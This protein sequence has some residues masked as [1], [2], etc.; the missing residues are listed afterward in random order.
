MGA[1][2]DRRTLLGGTLWAVLLRG[3]KLLA[4]DTA[5]EADSVC[6]RCRGLGLVPRASAKAYVFVEGQA[7]FDPAAAAVGQ[8]CPLCMKGGDE[9]E[10]VEQAKRQHADVLAQ[11]AQWESR[12]GEKLLLVQTRHAAIHTQLKV[13]DAKRVGEAVEQMAL[14]L[15]RVASSLAITP[16]RPA[17]YSQAIL[18]GEPA[19]TKFRAAMEQ[20]FTPE[21]LGEN[22]QNAGKGI[23]YDHPAVAHC[24]LTQKVIRDAPAEYFAVKLAATRQIWVATDTRSPAWMIEG[25]AAYAQHAVL[26]SARVFTIYAQGRGPTR[27]VTLAETA[28]QAAAGQFRPWEKLL[29][30]DLRDFEVTD[31]VQSL[32][33]VAFLVED[34]PAKF[35]AFVERLK[36]GTLVPAAFEEAY[37]ATAGDLE[38]ACGKWLA[39]R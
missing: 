3:G 38:T 39:R 13:A 27:P 21:Q 5:Q 30:R 29:A 8:N 22:W 10:L 31:Y 16:T 14:R 11:H 7:E 24:Y 25:M 36:A 1:G 26:G 9:A 28:R 33:M 2:L 17:G 12:L 19:W 35:L 15:Q 34:Q 18:W 4:Q 20:H 32:A 6:R 37:G 23:M